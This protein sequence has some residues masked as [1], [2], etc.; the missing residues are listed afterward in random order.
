M[1]EYMGR[2]KKKNRKKKK[3]MHTRTGM[4]SVAEIK[5]VQVHLSGL[6]IPLQTAEIISDSQATDS[7][8]QS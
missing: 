7:K 6:V 1:G 8:G 3:G 4:C 5:P 2:R